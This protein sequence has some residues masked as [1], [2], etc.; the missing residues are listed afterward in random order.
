MASKSGFWG[1]GVTEKEGDC[2]SVLSQGFHRVG[3]RAG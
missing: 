1:Q 3:S 2:V